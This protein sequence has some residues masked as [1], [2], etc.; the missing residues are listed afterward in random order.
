M[1][2][3]TLRFGPRA[4]RCARRRRMFRLLR[5]ARAEVAH[6]REDLRVNRLVTEGLITQRRREDRRAP[7]DT[8]A[9]AESAPSP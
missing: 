6:L 4:V 5:E 9:G 3:L 1:L 2:Q 7:S 8:T